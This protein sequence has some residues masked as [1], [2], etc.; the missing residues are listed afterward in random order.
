MRDD[1]TDVLIVEDNASDLELALRALSEH[2]PHHRVSVAR[3]GA[4][5]L[6]FMFGEGRFAGRRIGAQPRLVLLDLKLPLVD[7]IEVLSRI[8][9]DPRTRGLPVVALTAS[10]RESDVAEA[11]RRG[12]NSYLVKPVSFQTFAEAM[13]VV[14]AYWLMLNRPPQ[15][16]GS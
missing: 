1:E 9:T 7:G 12:V 14:G 13:K 3:D 16:Q 11:Y 2:Y 4:E 5:A 6:D 15:Q 8:R 10:A